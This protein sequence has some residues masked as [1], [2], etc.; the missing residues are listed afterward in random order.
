MEHLL[1][2]IV[3]HSDNEVPP[4]TRGTP[5]ILPFLQITFRITPAHA[6]NTNCHSLLYESF[7]DHPRLRGEH[8]HTPHMQ[9]GPMGSPPHTRGTRTSTVRMHRRIGIT[10]AYAGNT[11]SSFC[12]SSALRDHP[13]IR[14]EHEDP[15]PEHIET[16]GS[17]PHTR[18]TRRGYPC[19]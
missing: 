19:Q 6:G 5:P 12:D 10:P 9:S 4:H 17:P 14:G 16:P 18:G 13:R 11:C 1:G 7:W 15:M 3:L 8:F 2:H